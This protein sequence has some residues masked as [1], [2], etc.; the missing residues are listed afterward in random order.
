MGYDIY[1]RYELSMHAVACACAE[2]K[3]PA[4]YG[5]MSEGILLQNVAKL[6]LGGTTVASKYEKTQENKNSRLL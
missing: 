1:I 5:I 2:T 3:P 6:V 4:R